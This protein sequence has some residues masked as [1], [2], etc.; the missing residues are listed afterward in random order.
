MN[1][2]DFRIEE[3]FLSFAEGEQQEQVKQLFNKMI[4]GD[5]GEKY[6]ALKERE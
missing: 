1:L 3:V 6:E 5:N 2:S 4:W